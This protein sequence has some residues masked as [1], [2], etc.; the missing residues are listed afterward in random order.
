MKKLLCGEVSS[1]I[2]VPIVFIGLLMFVSFMGK[3]SGTRTYNVPTTQ[4]YTQPPQ[5]IQEDLMIYDALIGAGF[6]AE[7]S[8]DAV[9][10]TMD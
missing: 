6:S 2:V 3:M 8:R 9:I 4:N 1:L 7:E 10:N 5:T